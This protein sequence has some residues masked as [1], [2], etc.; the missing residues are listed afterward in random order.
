MD[1]RFRELLSFSKKERIAVF[2]LL[3]ISG[4]VWVVPAYFSRKK[5][6]DEWITITPLELMERE[7]IL[8]S[9]KDDSYK[10]I[11]KEHV[12]ESFSKVNILFHFDPNKASIKELLSLGLNERVAKSIINYRM[13][14]GKFKF[15][16]DIRKIYGLAPEMADRLIPFVRLDSALNKKLFSTELYKEAMPKTRLNINLADSTTLLSLPGVGMRLSSRIVR[17]R[18]RLGG[19]YELDQLK[20][21][22]GINDSLIEKITEL[23]AIDAGSIK[24]MNINEME[25]EELSRH[26]YIGFSKARLLIAYRNANGKIKNED[27]LKRAAM[28]DSLAIEKI[29]PYCLF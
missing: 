14:G 7:K 11:S 12:T 22:Y 10:V 23:V 13:K 9:R 3:I 27:E 28:F 17:Y 21:V 26:P 5:I 20:E 16:D 24:K 1:S 25:Y 15:A 8:L 18:L 6:H 2:L 29:L 19:F 4:L